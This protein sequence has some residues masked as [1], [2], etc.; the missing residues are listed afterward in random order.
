MHR[1]FSVADE[2]GVVMQDA[3]AHVSI[4]KWKVTGRF[5]LLMKRTWSCDV[6]LG[7]FGF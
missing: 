7:C 2:V 6:F 1:G 4:S 5:L 3:T